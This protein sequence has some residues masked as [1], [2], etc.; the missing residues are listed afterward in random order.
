M[1]FIRG[2][3]LRILPLAA[4]LAVAFPAPAQSGN[5]GA[6][7]SEERRVGDRRGYTRCLSDWSSDVC[8]SDLCRS[9]AARSFAFFPL[10]PCSLWRSPRPLKAETP[11]P[12]DR[13]SVVWGIAAVIRD[14]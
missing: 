3:I 7:R 10:P 12:S 6:V 5:A 9:F 11:A 4:L 1:P 8:S 14:A 13:K 2:A